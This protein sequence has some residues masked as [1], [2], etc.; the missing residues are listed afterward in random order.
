MKM[1]NISSSIQSFRYLLSNIFS[2]HLLQKCNLH[3]ENESPEKDCNPYSNVH[4]HVKSS[5]VLLY[6]IK[7]NICIEDLNLIIR[8]LGINLF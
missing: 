2:F 8:V 6:I 4:S 1:M 5:K 7:D 3:N